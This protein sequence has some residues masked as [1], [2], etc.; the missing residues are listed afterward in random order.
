M[1]TSKAKRDRK[2]YWQSLDGRLFRH[3]DGRRYRL[4]I[5]SHNQNDLHFERV[6][7]SDDNVLD[8]SNPHS[9]VFCVYLGSQ[10]LPADNLAALYNVTLVT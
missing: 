6:R 4:W 7:K 5:P 10:N 3:T 8:S 9:H 1:S 2:N